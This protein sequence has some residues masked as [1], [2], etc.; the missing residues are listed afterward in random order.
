MYLKKLYSTYLF[1]FTIRNLLPLII[2]THLIEYTT[3]E[4]AIAKYLKITKEHMKL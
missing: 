1:L 4:V 3:V 2:N